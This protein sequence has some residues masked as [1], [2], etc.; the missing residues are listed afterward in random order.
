MHLQVDWD[1]AKQSCKDAGMR[2]LQINTLAKQSTVQSVINLEK[3][4]DLIWIGLTDVAEEGR[5]RWGDGSLAL[6]KN[7][8][9]WNENSNQWNCAFIVAITGNSNSYKWETNACWAQRDFICETY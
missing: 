9:T 5:W 3:V 6:Y 4:S 7:W 1:T 8:G 2:L